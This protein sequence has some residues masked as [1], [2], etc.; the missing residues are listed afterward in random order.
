[1]QSFTEQVLH[2]I[3]NTGMLRML[4]LQCLIENVIIPM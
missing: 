1:M 2:I 3:L 4:H